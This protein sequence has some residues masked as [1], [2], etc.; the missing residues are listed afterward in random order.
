MEPVLSFAPDLSDA[1]GH[2]AGSLHQQLRAAILDGRIAPGATLPSSRNLA[3]E[4][5]IARN[6]V[7]GAYDLLVAEGYVLPR[8]GAKAVVADL[9]AR[10]SRGPVLAPPIE[11][12]RL[13]PFWRTPFLRPAP[14][15]L[16]ET[17]FRVGVPDW[18]HFPHET[19]RKLTAQALRSF[20]KA[21]FGYPASEGLPELRAA[22]AQHVAF[23]RAV[24]CTTS[25]DSSE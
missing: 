21:P 7:V 24:A 14:R 17:S 3:A 1:A 6:T 22:I 12:P 25:P 4:L 16:P 2:L 13:A 15:A 19:W 8:R 23:A 20:S 11:D 18:R 9:H 5:G 10:P